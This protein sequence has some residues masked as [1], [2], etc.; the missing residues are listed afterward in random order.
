M[1]TSIQP[2]IS[3][4]VPVYNAEKTLV[5]C[6]ESIL[7]QSYTSYEVLAINDGSDDA[8]LDILESYR[9]KYSNVFRII[10]QANHGAAYSRNVGIKKARGTFLAFI[11][12][13]DWIDPE[14]LETL[15]N[16]AIRNKADIVLSGYRR[17][18][19]SG[20]ILK[21]CL[22]SAQSEWAP[23]AV[24]AAWAKLYRRSFVLENKLT[25]LES[26]I[27]EDLAFTLPAIS[28]SSKTAI[29][30]YCGYNWYINP[31][32]VSNTAQHSSSRLEFEYAINEIAHLLKVST[33][34]N[35]SPDI[36]YLFIRHI[37][38]FLFWT[39]YGDSDQELRCNCKK[40][41]AWLD[42]NLP[43]WR[44]NTIGAPIH[45]T[46]DSLSSRLSTWLFMISPEAT[47]VL[48]LLFKRL[49]KLRS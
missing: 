27:S 48:L 36:E 34:A 22:L 12:N 4:I 45:P 49:Q 38:W 10:D 13:D 9:D 16:A 6:L 23:Y 37:V 19:A 31:T 42:A 30:D 43:L 39:S 25:F 14:Y 15:Y 41:T 26:N 33:G 7:E 21:K 8:S 2:S 5:R 1:Q 11:D 44:T 20:S 18:D 40:Y 47:L 17:P 46:G 32:S 29:L 24:E 3:I 28:A 35:I